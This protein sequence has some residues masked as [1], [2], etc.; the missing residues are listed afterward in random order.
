MG[1]RPDGQ[2]LLEQTRRLGA[3]WRDLS[4]VWRDEV[5]ARFE[6]QFW[7]PIIDGVTHYQTAVEHL[8]DVLGDVEQALAGR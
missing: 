5:A 4:G 1:Y 6:R 8:E 3:A 7:N 2:L